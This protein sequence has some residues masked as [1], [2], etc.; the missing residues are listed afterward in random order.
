MYNPTGCTQQLT[1]EGKK[2][3]PE[4]VGMTAHTHMAVKDTNTLILAAHSLVGR[5][6]GI[7]S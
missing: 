3:V 2:C 7:T 1:A 4:T 6:E 5:Q